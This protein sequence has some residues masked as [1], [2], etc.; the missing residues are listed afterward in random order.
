MLED[1]MRK[2]SDRYRAAAAAC[3]LL[4]ASAGCQ[5]LPE[6]NERTDL[7][8]QAEIEWDPD[9]LKAKEIIGTVS[10]YF[11]YAKL[12]Y[13]WYMWASGESAR[14]ARDLR[15]E[16]NSLHFQ[17][18]ALE[19]KVRQTDAFVDR[20]AVDGKITAIAGPRADVKTALDYQQMDD[21]RHAAELMA[22]SAANTLISERFYNLP[23]KNNGSRFDP[24]LATV[25]FVEAVTAWI[26]LRAANGKPI[27][28]ELRDN[29]LRYADH[30]ES[31]ARRTRDSV[32]CA[33]GCAVVEV[34]DRCEQEIDP[35]EPTPPCPTHEEASGYSFCSDGIA[36]K[37]DNGV[38]PRPQ[39]CSP[40]MGEWEESLSELATRV[41]ESR[42]APEVFEQTV[43][44]WRQIAG[45]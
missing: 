21:Y 42:Y 10:E 45:M 17:I 8:T 22:A 28:G 4:T 6:D 9:F 1:E 7:R 32:R 14:P 24:R 16:L 25:S 37:S 5:V 41:V 12:V 13:D 23:T 36:R 11:G 33:W 18:E 34:R 31:I 19:D 29:L 20:T 39:F 35:W 43:G 30:L 26:A 27:D 15:N 2:F 3:A 40:G 44:L 38:V